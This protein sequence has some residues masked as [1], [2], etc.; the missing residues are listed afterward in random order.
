VAVLTKT[1][2]LTR[3]AHLTK[4]A[5]FIARIFTVPIHDHPQYRVFHIR[6]NFAPFGRLAT[7]SAEVRAKLY[8]ELLLKYPPLFCGLKTSVQVVKE[9]ER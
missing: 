2:H 1:I 3:K 4:I 9:T 5:Q 7:Y 8:P 6:G